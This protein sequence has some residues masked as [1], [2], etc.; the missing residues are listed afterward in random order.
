MVTA[1]PTGPRW[2]SDRDRRDRMNQVT[3]LLQFLL[4]LLLGDSTGPNPVTTGAIYGTITDGSGEP[5]IGATV[6]IEKPDIGAMTDATGSYRID[7]LKPGFYMLEARMV[8]MESVVMAPVYVPPDSAVRVDFLLTTG[9]ASPRTLVRRRLGES[10]I[11]IRLDPPQDPSTSGLVLTIVLNGYPYAVGWEL[12]SDSV[13]KVNALSEEIVF[14]WSS[15]ALGTRWLP[16]HLK[17]GLEN[18]LTLSLDPES[19]DIAL[20]CIPIDPASDSD[21]MAVGELPWDE[22]ID[23]AFRMERTCIDLLD[24]ENDTLEN[25]AP[26]KTR[27]CWDESGRWRV[28][29]AYRERIV[30]LREGLPSVTIDLPFRTEHTHVLLSEEGRYA[31]V[32][33]R[34]TSDPYKH[35]IMVDIDRREIL[36]LDP[37]TQDS[38]LQLSNRPLPYHDPFHTMWGLSGTV[39]DNGVLVVMED[40]S[41]H[42]CRAEDSSP[43]ALEWDTLEVALEVFGVTENDKMLAYSWDPSIQSLLHDTADPDDFLAH[44]VVD[45]DNSLAFQPIE[46]GNWSGTWTHDLRF[47]YLP[48]SQELLIRNARTG[49]MCF[50]DALTGQHVRDFSPMIE[51]GSAWIRDA[52]LSLDGSFL[53]MILLNRVTG[54]NI[55][56]LIARN[57]LNMPVSVPSGSLGQW[58]LVGSRGLWSDGQMLRDMFI[59]GERAPLGQSVGYPRRMALF[60]S[61]GQLLWLGP[62]R[63]HSYIEESVLAVDDDLAF[64][65]TD[66]RQIQICRLVPIDE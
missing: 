14:G 19:I 2:T 3:L 32:A 59:P 35:C 40:E 39:F 58:E 42:F 5:L 38:L 43:E 45:R 44:C 62:S 54:R 34:S 65:W 49:G 56:L 60:N 10:T 4:A 37:T 57:L 22:W 33:P 50:I 36:G 23:P 28:V 15:P 21:T 13:L 18:S 12:Q 51:V 29:L 26:L 11:S 20:D 8:G 24:W 52:R 30:L 53:A 7:G 9:W 16:L 47:Q 48:G 64:I 41:T 55:G 46:P 25:A 31:V 27:A 1:L 6:L 63:Y 61:D 66:H 17:Q